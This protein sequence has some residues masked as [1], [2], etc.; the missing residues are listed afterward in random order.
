MYIGLICYRYKV[1]TECYLYFGNIGGHYEK[2]HKNCSNSM[3]SFFNRCA[4]FGCEWDNK[5]VWWVTNCN[6]LLHDSCALFKSV[7][8]FN[9]KKEKQRQHKISI[10]R[11]ENH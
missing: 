9:R 11:S 5:W 6:V 2:F 10:K 4:N 7:D 8:I 1:K 3:Y